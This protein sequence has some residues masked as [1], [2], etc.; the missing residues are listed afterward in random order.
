M[1]YGTPLHVALSNQE[2]KISYK[3]LKM[4]K[5]IKDFNPVQDLNKMDDDG[6]N[7]LHNIMRHF[8]VDKDMAKKIALFMIKRGVNLDFKNKHKHTPLLYAI[9]YAQNEA[10]K[11]ALTHNRM[12]RQ[13]KNIEDPVR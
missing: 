2:F 7:P 11:F 6:N 4:L 12:V 9:Y 3:L 10:V 8:N 5:N 13:I 1:K